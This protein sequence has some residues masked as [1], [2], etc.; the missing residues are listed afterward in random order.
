MRNIEYKNS[1]K[2][3]KNIIGKDES[4]TMEW[5]PSLSQID[6]IV[7]AVSGFSN[8]KGGKIIVGVSRTG[9]ILGVDIGK[10]TIEQLTNK[11]VDNTDPKVYPSIS[12]K[13]VQGKK[14]IVIQVKEST[15]KLVLAFGRPYKRIGKSTLRMIRDEYERVILEKHKEK[16]QFDKQVCKEATLEDIDKEE[17]IR[18]LKKYKIERNLEVDFKASIKEVLEKLSL[19]T[20]G[21]LTNAAILLFGKD[22][23]RFFMQ[24]TA[25]CAKFKGNEPLEFIDMKVFRKNIIE[26]REDIIEFIKEHIKLHAE[27][28]ETERVEKWEYPIEAIRE[29]VTNAICHRDYELHGNVQIRIFDD[30][31]EVWGCGPLPLP[32][33]PDDLKRKHKSILRNPLIGKCFFLIKYI[34]EWGTGTNRMIKWCLKYGLPEPIFEEVA[35]DFVVT[36]RKYVDENMLKELSNRQRRIVDY[37]RKHKKIDRSETINLLNVSKN[38]TLRVLSGLQTIGVVKRTGK[39]KNICYVLK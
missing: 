4:D 22:P 7:K 16:L 37:L 26:Q 14:I 28:V 32:L 2:I 33:T 3:L 20:N 9:E 24:A 29:A 39:G 13:S 10:N 19:V 36:F 38:T 18:F 23:Q 1:K 11:I 35:G 17:I 15:D 6:E 27:I 5:K 34:E 31:L 12:V 25:K 8:E 21:K 30:R